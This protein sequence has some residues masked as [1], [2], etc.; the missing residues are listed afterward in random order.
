MTNATLATLYKMLTGATTLRAAL[1]TCMLDDIPVDCLVA[2]E[3][4]ASVEARG[5][6]K[7]HVYPIAIMM[8]DDLSGRLTDSNG[9]LL[10]PIVM[11]EERQ[12]LIEELEEP[13]GRNYSVTKEVGSDEDPH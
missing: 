5:G 13:F 10:Q 7:H 12:Q 6:D 4:E 8:S 3:S 9:T 1:T 11:T 2:V